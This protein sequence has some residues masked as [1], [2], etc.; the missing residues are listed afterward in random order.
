MPAGAKAPPGG[1][2][3]PALFTITAAA[4]KSGAEGP[5]AGSSTPP[6]VNKVAKKPLAHSG[7][8]AFHTVKIDRLLIDRKATGIHAA[9]REI[10][11]KLKEK[12][13]SFAME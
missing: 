5:E 10:G 4:S 6:S 7:D 3:P 11:A 13:V 8:I 2:G 12:K 1:I 9:S